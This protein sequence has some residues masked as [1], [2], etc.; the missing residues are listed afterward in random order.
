MFVDECYIYIYIDAICFCLCSQI[1]LLIAAGFGL[2]FRK[3]FP[4]FSIPGNNSRLVVLIRVKNLDDTVFT[5]KKICQFHFL[6]DR[7][8]FIAK[9]F[10]FLSS[11]ALSKNIF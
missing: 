3:R 1:F 8:T 2:M 5:G 9:Y 11:L 4:T 6:M 7:S 10:F